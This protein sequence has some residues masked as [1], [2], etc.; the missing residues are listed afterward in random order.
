M[1]MNRVLVVGTSEGQCTSLASDLRD[2]VPEA[3][4]ESALIHSA[5][6]VEAYDAILLRAD[7]PENFNWMR[8]VRETGNEVP[9]LLVSSEDSRR[10]QERALASGAT[11]VVLSTRG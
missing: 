2:S 7:Q 9:I 8:R 1:S 3:L 11:E 4:F 10:F 6:P 5:I